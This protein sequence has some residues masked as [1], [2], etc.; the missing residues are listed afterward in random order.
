MIDELRE[1]ENLLN[2]IDDLE[3]VET[4]NE[5][6]TTRDIYNNLENMI[7]DYQDEIS[8]EVE[9]I[10]IELS[11]YNFTINKIMMLETKEE[12]EKEFLK[13]SDK[14]DLES[15]TSELEEKTNDKEELKKIL[16]SFDNITYY[17]MDTVSEC[18]KI[19]KKLESK[20]NW[21]LYDLL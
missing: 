5:Y 19:I 10:S 21:R 15:I 9:T 18:L 20:E 4:N 14:I 17:N 8:K 1:L 16:D 6:E 13:L 7:L 12:I 3:S 2:N 11:E